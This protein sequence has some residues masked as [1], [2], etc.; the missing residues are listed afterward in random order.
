[1]HHD[2]ARTAT[3][4]DAPEKALQNAVRFLAFAMTYATTEEV[5]VIRR[6]FND[7][8]L[9][10]ALDDAPPRFFDLRSWAY[11][12]V[13]FG[14]YPVP[15]MPRRRFPKRAKRGASGRRQSLA[16]ST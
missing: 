5:T 14:R 10:D 16:R 11:W 13:M 6:H 8:E 15:P 3:S 7:G 12:N 4:R 9:E 2:G 1:V